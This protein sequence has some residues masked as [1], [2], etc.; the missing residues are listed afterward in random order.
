MIISQFTKDYHEKMFPGYIPKF[1]ET[2]PEFIERFDSFAF[3]EVLNQPGVQPDDKT[4]FLAIIT[5]WP[6]TAL[7]TTTPGPGWM[8]GSGR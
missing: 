1:P 4:R 2:D 6:T 5:G 8:T 3:D 7:G